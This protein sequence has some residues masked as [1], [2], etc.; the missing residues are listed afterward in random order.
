MHSLT[1]IATSNEHINHSSSLAPIDIGVHVRVPVSATLI[2]CVGFS[3][4]LGRLRPAESHL[5]EPA[6]VVREY[7]VT[8]VTCLL[9]AALGETALVVV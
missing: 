3:N 5:V 8:A 4:A 6:E 2:V 9:Q 7:I 1:R